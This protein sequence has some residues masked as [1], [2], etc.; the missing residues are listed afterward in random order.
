MIRA[1]T[2]RKT[3]YDWHAGQ[4][5]AFYAAA[6]S[7][8]IS[9][10]DWRRIFDECTSMTDERERRDLS[11]WLGHQLNHAPV[12]ALDSRGRTLDTA[13]AHHD[14]LYTVLPWAEQHP[15]NRNR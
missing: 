12:V 7:G 3:L 14:Q 10:D 2:A 8:L 5:S 9:T 6:S 13:T 1:E 15:R 4:W 11:Y